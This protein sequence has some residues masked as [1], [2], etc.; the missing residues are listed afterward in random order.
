MFLTYGLFFIHRQNKFF[1]HR[2]PSTDQKVKS[3]E[4]N[5]R[6]N[7]HYNNK[8][9][10]KYRTFSFSHIL[11]G[12]SSL[13]CMQGAL[14]HIPCVCLTGKLAILC[15]KNGL[16][17]HLK[18]VP[19]RNCCCI[20]FSLTFRKI[21]ICYCRWYILTQSSYTMSPKGLVH[22]SMNHRFFDNYSLI[23]FTTRLT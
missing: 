13:T 9:E 14:L 5:R 3:K 6:W 18:K 10:I 23:N 11:A 19:P 22:R 8:N 17:W 15:W 1:I 7:R 21:C 2:C 4:V 20:F 16:F 12:S